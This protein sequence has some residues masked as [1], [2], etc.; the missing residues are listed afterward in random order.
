[1]GQQSSRKARKGCKDKDGEGESL[2]DP[3]YS[4]PPGNVN[5]VDE[6]VSDESSRAFAPGHILLNSSR[7][8]SRAN[9]APDKENHDAP[10]YD[11]PSATILSTGSGLDTNFAKTQLYPP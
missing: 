6:E 8:I 4:E 3:N 7:Q 5:Y 11:K 1:M 2:S 10:M 9:C